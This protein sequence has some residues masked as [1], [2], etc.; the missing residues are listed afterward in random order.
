MELKKVSIH[1]T[2]RK[3]KGGGLEYFPIERTLYFNLLSVYAFI[4]M[5]KD[6]TDVIGIICYYF[7]TIVLNY[8]SIFFHFEL[9]SNR[10]FNILS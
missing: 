3:K 8:R 9:K 6:K 4:C 1:P 2:F 10:V 5:Q 7:F